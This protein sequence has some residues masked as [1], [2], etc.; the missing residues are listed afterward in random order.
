[1]TEQAFK[2]FPESSIKLTGHPSLLGS[3][4]KVQ[5]HIRV[6][7]EEKGGGRTGFGGRGHNRN[8]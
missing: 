2:N 4:K 1:M 3:Q 6:V 7:S 5:Q 8:M